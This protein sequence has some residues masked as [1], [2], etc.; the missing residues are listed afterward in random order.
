M[1]RLV[2]RGLCEVCGCGFDRS[3]TRAKYCTPSHRQWA[4]RNR[5]RVTERMKGYMLDAGSL[6]DLVQVRKISPAAELM[7]LKVCSVAGRE[8]ACDVLDG[9]F[10]VVSSLQKSGVYIS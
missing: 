3:S 10:A 5:K 1:G 4:Y 2:S 7:V 6:K 8:L 9:I